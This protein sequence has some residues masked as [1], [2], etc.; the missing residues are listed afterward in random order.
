MPA[1]ENYP[2]LVVCTQLSGKIGGLFV[3]KTAVDADAEDL[4]VRLFECGDISLICL[5]LLRSPPGESQNVECKYDIF[6]ST[7]VTQLRFLAFRVRQGKVRRA[8][9][10][11][12]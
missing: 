1:D 9:A 10:D 5:E 7:K 11:T 3:G 6:L 12:K 2:A 8:V 4:R